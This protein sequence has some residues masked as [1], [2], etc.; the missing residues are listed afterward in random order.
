MNHGPEVALLLIELAQPLQIFLHLITV[1]G[2]G[3]E[4]QEGGNTH[5]ARILHGPHQ[6]AVGETPVALKR[7]LSDFDLRAFLYYEDQDHRIGRDAAGHVGHLGKHAA[8][9][10]QH[11]GQ[12]HFRPAHPRGVVLHFH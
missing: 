11:L 10:G 9:L 3:H 8:A 7:N 4:V 1:V 2:F 12:H 5:G 6:R